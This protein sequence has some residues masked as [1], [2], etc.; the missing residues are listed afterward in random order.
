MSDF[1]DFDGCWINRDLIRA[2]YL[3]PERAKPTVVVRFTDD[4]MVFVVF[5]NIQLANEAIEHVIS[6]V[7]DRVSKTRIDGKSLGFSIR[8][9]NCLKALGIRTVG[10]LVKYSADDLLAV[11]NFGLTSLHE[12]EGSLERIGVCLSP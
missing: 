6:G 7:P 8:T 5:D 4:D 11:N 10:E 2:V 1:I 9:T 12:V 3:D